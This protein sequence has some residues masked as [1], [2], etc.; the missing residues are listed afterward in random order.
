MSALLE[1]KAVSRYFG[2]LRAVDNIDVHLNEGEILGLIGPNGAGKTTLLNL[3]SGALPVSNGTI[4]FKG[5]RI[6]HL[7]PHVRA[8]MGIARTFQIVRPF[9]KLSVADN[10]LVGLG[11]EQY[12]RILTSLKR[13]RDPGTSEQVDRILELVGLAHLKDTPAYTLPLGILRRVEI[14]RALALNPLVL[15]LDEPVAGL[16]EEERSAVA[17]LLQ[18]IRTQN[19]S[20]LLVEHTMSFVMGLCERIVVMHQGKKIAE[21]SPNEIVANPQ[22]IE[23]YL[24][25]R[26]GIHVT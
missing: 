25:T 9:A 8:K 15:L 24:G 26:K 21:G 17:K 7:P 2:G 10:V 11:C 23:V 6:D 5:V 13:C 18:K 20:I 22:V 14:A 3:I 16:T 12:S 4:F 19:V 1:T